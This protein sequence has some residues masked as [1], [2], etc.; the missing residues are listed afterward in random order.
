VTAPFPD[1]LTQ[2]RRLLAML[3]GCPQRCPHLRQGGPQPALA[4][5]ALRR[6][7]CLACA[8]TVPAPPAAD[9]DRCDGCGQ[10]GVRWFTPLVACRGPLLVVGDVC[11]TCA[12]ALGLGAG[13]GPRR[14]ARH[15][16]Q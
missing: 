9:H 5:L 8:A 10:R 16:P 13:A 14:R 11:A 12:A 15:G 4:R 7:D 6:A 1:R 2:A 3:L